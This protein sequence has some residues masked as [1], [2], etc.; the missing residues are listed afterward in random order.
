M[1]LKP[2]TVRS[3]AEHPTG[4]HASPRSHPLLLN[5][6][7]CH[8]PLAYVPPT[9]TAS[10]AW[11]TQETGFFLLAQFATKMSLRKPSDAQMSC[12]VILHDRGGSCPD[13]SRSDEVQTIPSLS[14]HPPLL[15]HAHHFAWKNKTAVGLLG[16][17]TWPCLL[18]RGLKGKT[19]TSGM[20]RVLDWIPESG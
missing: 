3:A 17:T 5:P 9:L 13:T 15:Y 7:K 6:D 20:G 14:H 18:V 11:Y 12:H 2:K 1:K 16:R 19:G 4:L 10:C 8:D